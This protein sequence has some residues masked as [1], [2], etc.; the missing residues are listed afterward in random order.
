MQ[1]YTTEMKT[2]NVIGFLLVALMLSS[3][4]SLRSYDYTVEK[5]NLSNQNLKRVPA[6]ILRYRNLKELNLQ[7]NRIKHIPAWVSSLDSLEEINLNNNRLRLNRADVR[8]IKVLSPLMPV[9]L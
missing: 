2:K 8:Q 5:L 4:A 7:N 1:R 6:Y 9:P 3:C